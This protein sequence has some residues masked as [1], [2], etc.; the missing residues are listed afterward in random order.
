[1]KKRLVS[2]KIMCLIMTLIIVTSGNT[3]ILASNHG[4]LNSTAIHHSEF[5]NP[6][7]TNGEYGRFEPTTI[8][9]EDGELTIL[10]RVISEVH[11]ERD[12]SAPSFIAVEFGFVRLNTGIFQFRFRL[13]HLFGQPVSISSTIATVSTGTQERGPFTAI[14]GTYRTDNPR[15][16]NW[17]TIGGPPITPRTAHFNIRID[18]SSPSLLI[19]SVAEMHFL[20]NRTGNVWDYDWT[21][22]I[23]G[24]R[25][26]SPPSNWTRTNPGPNTY[27]YRISYI[28]WF[29]THFDASFNPSPLTHIHHIRPWAFGGTNAVANLIHIPAPHHRLIS[30]WFNGY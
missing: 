1:M 10:G 17:H 6:N 19:P 11:N 15:F 22:T 27:P 16:N 3:V 23:S 25:I 28:N 12:R 30:S 13:H 4:L 29:R 2:M 8:Q 18:V 5:I 21:C 9:T 20:I 26:T 24:R 7:S 14:A